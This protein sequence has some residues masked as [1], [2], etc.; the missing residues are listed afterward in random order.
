MVI[1]PALGA[2]ML[3]WQTVQDGLAESTTVCV[4]DR[5]G[6][7]WSDPGG[8]PSAPGMARELRGLLDAADIAPP[9]VIAGHT[10]AAWWPGCS[11]SCTWMR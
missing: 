10:S 5:P 11:R 7:G 6:L 9:F 3:E 8:W 1:I 4:Y 2:T